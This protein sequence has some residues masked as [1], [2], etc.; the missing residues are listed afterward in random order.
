LLKKPD[1]LFRDSINEDAEAMLDGN[2]KWLRRLG[3]RCFF[4]PDMERMFS[5][6]SIQSMSIHRSME[7]DLT[8][9]QSEVSLGQFSHHTVV[10]MDHDRNVSQNPSQSTAEF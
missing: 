7:W 9:E 10:P 1:F 6:L 8:E 3:E 4:L 5:L 2:Y